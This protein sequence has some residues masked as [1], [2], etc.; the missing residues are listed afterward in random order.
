MMANER[1][2]SGDGA[3]TAPAD[4]P[5]DEEGVTADAGHGRLASQRQGNIRH[6]LRGDVGRAKLSASPP[7]LVEQ[8]FARLSDEEL[9][10]YHTGGNS[11]QDQTACAAR[12]LDIRLV[13]GRPWVWV[14]R[15]VRGGAIQ[16]AMDMPGSRGAIVARNGRRRPR[17]DDRRRIRHPGLFTA[18]LQA[19]LQRL[20]TSPDLAERHSRNHIL[21][22]KARP[23]ARVRSF[24]GRWPTSWPPGVTVTPGTCCNSG[25]AWGQTHSAPLRP[26][27]PTA[28]IRELVNNPT[29]VV[30]HGT[31]YENRANLAS[32]FFRQ[33]IKRYEGTRLGRQ[34]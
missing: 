10:I 2:E 18:R 17:R 19:G 24:I 4:A 6:P 21:S 20:Q 33:V 26:P 1:H 29:C 27:R 14:P 25:C 28:V 3:D 11:G 15:S 34:S 8:F 13:V 32:N 7:E 5:D 12:R 31:T 23:A 16:K 22:G 30:I 9:Y